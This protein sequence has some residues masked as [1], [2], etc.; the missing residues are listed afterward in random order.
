M[1][2]RGNL[3]LPAVDHDNYPDGEIIDILRR[4]K[5]VAIVGASA[6][7][8]RP[9][10]FVMKYLRD[11]G[12]DVLPVNPGQAGKDILGQQ[13]VA[14][15]ADLPVS[16]DMVDIFRASDAVPQLV[17]EILAMPSLPK[18]VWMQLGV[19]DDAAAA[20]LEAAG[21]RVIMNRCPK[22]EYARLSGEIGW[23]GVNSRKISSRKPV[24]RDGYQSFGIRQNCDD[25]TS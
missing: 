6:N 12:Y 25:S 24:L 5:T 2:E 23:S 22:I 11:K 21:I 7:P 8:V 14:A 3:R 13:A 19:R 15:L 16:V 9:S 17:D 1:D 20:R 4:V 10:Y 18:V